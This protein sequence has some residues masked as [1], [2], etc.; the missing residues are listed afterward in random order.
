M[1]SSV[2]SAAVI[3]VDAVEVEKFEASRKKWDEEHRNPKT[4]RDAIP[5]YERGGRTFMGLGGDSL[6]VRETANA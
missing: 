2:E 5:M 3:V 1:A 6:P 4:N